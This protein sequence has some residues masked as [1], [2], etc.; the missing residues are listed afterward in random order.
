[1][2]NQCFNKSDSNLEN[3]QVSLSWLGQTQTV[4]FV[5]PTPVE[6]RSVGK[7][8]YFAQN[9]LDF[10]RRSESLNSLKARY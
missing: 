5:T 8:F 7:L 2:L 1:M 4:C 10:F 3:S 6:I 9:I